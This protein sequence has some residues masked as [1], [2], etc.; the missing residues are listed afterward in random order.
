MCWLQ[1]N[2]L[3]AGRDPSLDVSVQLCTSS[4]AFCNWDYNATAIAEG[5]SDYRSREDC[6]NR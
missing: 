6:E 3:I 4:G 5:S 1:N 2:I